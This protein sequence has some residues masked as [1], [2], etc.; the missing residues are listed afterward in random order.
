MNIRSIRL[1]KLIGYQH[2][3]GGVRKSI[4]QAEAEMMSGIVRTVWACPQPSDDGELRYDW[5]ETK[6][7][8]DEVT[9]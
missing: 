5:Q 3:L 4:I 9:G 7:A 6:P 1:T 2:G 8:L